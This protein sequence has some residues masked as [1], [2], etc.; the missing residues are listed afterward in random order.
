[1]P[2]GGVGGWSEM[3]LVLILSYKQGP[4]L[5][6]G[7][8]LAVPQLGGGAPGLVPQA[9]HGLTGGTGPVSV[10]KLPR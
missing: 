1:M 8:P 10:M 2:G 3:N 5:E 7:D 9:G 6:T 4:H